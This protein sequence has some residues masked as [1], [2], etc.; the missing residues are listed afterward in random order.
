MKKIFR[1]KRLGSTPVAS[2]PTV[3]G[4]WRISPQEDLSKRGASAGPSKT[5]GQGSPQ[6]NC[7]EVKLRIKGHLSIRLGSSPRTREQAQYACTNFL[8]QYGESIEKSGLYWTAVIILARKL[9]SV[10]P[11]G[12]NSDY[13]ASLDE[14]ISILTTIA[15]DLLNDIPKLEMSYGTQEGISGRFG[16]ISIQLTP[17]RSP[18]LPLRAVLA[19]IKLPAEKFIK[20]AETFGVTYE[21]IQGKIVLH[22]TTQSRS[23][24]REVVL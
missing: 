10:H 21:L 17:T 16:I 8:D 14:N 6:C 11:G 3:P 24:L 4:P 18:A 12:G 19:K 5:K 1:S 7:R 22:T 20:M 9:Q 23:H 15:S 2:A 13:T